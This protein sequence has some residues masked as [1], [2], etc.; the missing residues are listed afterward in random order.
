MIVMISYN[1]YCKLITDLTNIYLLDACHQRGYTFRFDLYL[2]LFFLHFLKEYD[3]K[4]YADPVALLL[5]PPPSGDYIK[6]SDEVC[7][8][9][10]CNTFRLFL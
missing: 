9:F 10:N 4:T 6:R 2:F 8:G 7:P 5:P 1:L 3:L